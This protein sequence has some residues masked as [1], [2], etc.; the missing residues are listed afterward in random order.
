[1]IRRISIIALSAA[2][3]SGTPSLAEVREVSQRELR[4]IV[5]NG[6]GMGL[7]P[8]LK[9]VAHQTD[10][11]AV[12]VRVFDDGGLI[13]SILVMLPNGKMGTVF[14]DGQSGELVSP[15]TKR[16]GA[17][18]AAAKASPGQKSNNSGAASKSQGK[19]KGKS[20]TASK[21]KSNGKGKK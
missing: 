6:Q 21:G 10:G 17:I 19:S 15:W 7:G 11:E 12:D 9:S 8:I 13:Y 3:L 16:A 14:V 20:D 1:M 2:L 5:A 4:A 18:K